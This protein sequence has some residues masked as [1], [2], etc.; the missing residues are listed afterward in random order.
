[1]LYLQDL[2]SLSRDTKELF[3]DQL[4]NSNVSTPSWASQKMFT[5]TLSQDNFDE[6][7]DGWTSLTE[8]NTSAQDPCTYFTETQHVFSTPNALGISAEENSNFN[9]FGNWYNDFVLEDIDDCATIKVK[10]D[11]ITEGL[12]TGFYALVIDLY[13]S[14]TS[15]TEFSRYFSIIESGS[16]L[17]SYQNFETKAICVPTGAVRLRV[18]LYLQTQSQASVYVDNFKIDVFE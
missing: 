1:L 14:Q 13:D 7:I 10:A 5:Q 18:R 2:Y 15:D 8:N 16:G 4:L 3:L 6:A 11:V 12:S 9:A 17:N